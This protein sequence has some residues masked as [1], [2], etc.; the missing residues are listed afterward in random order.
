M[1]IVVDAFTMENLENIINYI[2]GRIEKREEN[3]NKNSEK[4]V[5]EIM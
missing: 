2:L 5:D 4:E 3:I 1:D